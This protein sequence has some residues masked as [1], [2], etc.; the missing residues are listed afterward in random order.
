MKRVLSFVMAAALVTSLI[1]ATAFAAKEDVKATAKVVGAVK[2]DGSN[3]NVTGEKVGQV[4]SLPVPDLHIKVTEA[5]YATGYNGKA[6][7]TVTLDGA[8]FKDGLNASIEKSGNANIDSTTINPKDKSELDIVVS[9]KLEK[10][11]IIKLPLKS[12]LTKANKG[13]RVSVESDDITVKADDM[14]YVIVSDAGFKASVKKTVKVA[15]DEVVK[16][17]DN[18]IKIS[19]T[20]DGSYTGGNIKYNIITL[21]LSKGF[22]FAGRTADV[23]VKD[24]A[25]ADAKDS[26]TFDRNTAT[27]KTKTVTTANSDLTITG[28]KIE[29]DGAK[30]GS[31]A[32]MT[33]TVENYDN[34]NKRLDTLKNVSL[35]VAEVVDY[36]VVMSVDKDKD[37]PTMYSGVNVNNE[38]ITDNSNHKTV[39]ISLEETFPG[40]WSMRQ[41][42]NLTLPQGVYVTDVEIK[43]ADNFMQNGKAVTS[44]DAKK[45]W[46]D[47]FEK[48][49]KDGKYEKFEFGKRLFDD[50]NTN[51]PD[52]N[53]PAKLSF[54]LVLVA[55]PN[56]EGDVKIGLEGSMLDKQSVTVAK[57]VAPYKVEAQQNDLKIDSRFTKVPTD[58]VVKETADG[59]WD[60]GRQAAKF[61]FNI[62]KNLI[63]FE[64]DAK[65][66][67]DKNSGMEV[68]DS[69]KDN[70]LAFTV[71]TVSDKAAT[72][73][74]SDMELFMD[75]SIPTGR[76]ALEM[77]STMSE[78]YVAQKLFANA[79][80]TAKTDARDNASGT[81]LKGDNY[82]G[83][84]TDYKNTVKN[85]FVNVI[86]A[87][88]DEDGFTTKISVPVGEKYVLA[89][90]KKVE[91]DTPAYINKDGYTMLP[92]RAVA[93]ALG[94][95]SN[96][97]IWDQT[98]RT[99]TII[100]GQ[101]IVSMQNGAKMMYINGQ[102]VP[103]KAGVEITNDRVFLS[104]R[105]LGTAMN[106]KDVS[107]DGATKTAYLNAGE[108][109]A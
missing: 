64:K 76:Y 6:T 3:T 73:T 74:I 60:K 38:G 79:D 80:A 13:A 55:D 107:W 101:R 33:I 57:F 31:K 25:K 102:G 56:F 96:S 46:K 95:D 43:D 77:T 68:T 37:L 15:E 53:D 16:L 26:V 51:T 81:K 5:A 89:G 29:A 98:T 65:F 23:E 88:R 19:E 99:A 59:L 40:A 72:V 84:V 94:V 28:L 50:V 93:V 14:G 27:I 91:I 86:T 52:V 63:R 36:K 69:Q 21:K 58:I 48:A 104:L 54:V 32:T 47:A 83:D 49:Y 8:E 42:F 30:S 87:P 10:D 71:K 9:G 20:V 67:A 11:D 12:T 70:K 82:I 7:I 24:G 90:E 103:T 85:N 97:V 75:R 106:V 39:E 18:G 44:A 45:A 62:E 66:T 61:T 22:E 35:E 1:P 105:D 109:Q 34:T 92:L 4:E 78:G 100:Y 2:T 41:G 108:K 17:H